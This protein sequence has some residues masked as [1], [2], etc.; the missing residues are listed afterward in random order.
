MARIR[1]IKPEFF[2]DEDVGHLPP[3]V[4]LLFIAMWTE[5]DKA[6]RLKDKPKT[7]KARCL[8][9]DKVDIEEAIQQLADANFIVRY[10]VEGTG[11]IQIRTWEEH[12]RPH[13]TERASTIP[14]RVNGEIT[15]KQPL[16]NGVNDSVNPPFPSCILPSSLEGS[17]EFKDA[18]ESWIKHRKQIKKPLTGEQIKKQLATFA[19]WGVPRSVTAIEHT[20]RQGWQGLREPDVPRD[21]FG[22]PAPAEMSAAEYKADLARRAKRSIDYATGGGA[23]G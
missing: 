7:L 18:W 6:G 20:I 1:S 21:K 10:T 13:H 19:E 15:V 22:K 8:P 5:A 14:E 12:Q 17:C 11:Y 23:G 4:R 9:F 2:S 3:A 16:L